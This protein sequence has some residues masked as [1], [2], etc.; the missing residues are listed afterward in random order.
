MALLTD[1]SPNDNEGLR[2]YESGILDVAHVEAI[3]LQAK[4]GLATAEVSEDVLDV[5]LDHSTDPQGTARRSLGVSGVVVTPQMKRWHAVHTLEIVYRDAFNNQLNDR[6]LAKFRE[7]QE[8]S[9]HARGHAVRFGIGLVA[10]PIPK[11]Q[12]PTLS[13]AAGFLLATTY[14]AQVSWLNSQGQEGAPSELTT[15]DSPEGS[16]LVIQAV[17]PP[18]NATGWNVFVGLS[19]TTLTQQNSVPLS[20]GGSFTLSDAGV[21]AGRAPGDGQRPDV[22][23]VGGPLLRRG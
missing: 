17:N 2:V 11:A 4:L 9:R 23:V 1:G 18:A 8:L 7:Y 19:S 16:R 3:D 15:F 13:F 14:Y 12:T 20:V 22:Y 6:Y 5:L 21:A 10:D